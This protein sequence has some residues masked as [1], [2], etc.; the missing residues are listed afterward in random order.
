MI[1]MGQAQEI[2]PLPPKVRAMLDDQGVYIAGDSTRP[3]LV[4]VLISLGGSVHSMQVDIELDPRRFLPTL[5]LHGPYLAKPKRNRAAEWGEYL[6][7]GAENLMTALDEFR[8]AQEAV[9]NCDDGA[10]TMLESAT[11]TLG[12]MLRG[13][14]SDI[15]E[16]RKRVAQD[17]AG[18]A[19]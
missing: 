14:R 12:D 17:A 1:L 18:E 7:K 15:Y 11:E 19:Q 2:D 13:V 8:V 5:T 6:A 16:F 9:E 3:D 10:D 4:V